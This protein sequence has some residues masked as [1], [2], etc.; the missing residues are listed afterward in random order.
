MGMRKHNRCVARLALLAALLGVNGCLATLEQ[1]LDYLL[2]PGALE[3]TQ[4]LPFSNVAPL[5]QFLFNLVA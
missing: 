4:F 2:A 1:N 5:A 3:N